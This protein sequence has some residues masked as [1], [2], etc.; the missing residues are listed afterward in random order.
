MRRTTVSYRGKMKG[1]QLYEGK[2][3]EDLVEER[4]DGEEVDMGTKPLNY[5]VREDGVLYG[6]D[7]RGDKWDNAQGAIDYVERSRRAA[8]ERFAKEEKEAK[9][10]SAKTGGTE[11]SQGTAKP[12]PPGDN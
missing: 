9:D 3:I 7:I 12:T 8:K 1:V 5:T 10:K 11:S 2:S 6:T 4:M